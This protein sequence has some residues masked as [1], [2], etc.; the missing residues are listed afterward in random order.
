MNDPDI[1]VVVLTEILPKNNRYMLQK[2]E[3]EIRGFTNNYE[4]EVL[5]GLLYM[6]R[7]VV[8]A[9]QVYIQIVQMILSGWN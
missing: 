5:E 9:N 2:S 1:V 8:T 6:Q 3:L 4:L 7:S